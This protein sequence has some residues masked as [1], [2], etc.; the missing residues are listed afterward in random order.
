[1]EQIKNLPQQEVDI[2]MEPSTKE[3][4]KLNEMI[5][6]PD[7]M[8]GLHI[9]EAGIVLARYVYFNSELFTDKS[10]MELG[11]GVGVVGIALLKYCKPRSVE[12]SDYKEDILNN[13]V[14]NAKKNKVWTKIP[15]KGRL[16]DWVDY[17]K[18]KNKYDIIIGSDLIYAGAPV[19]ELSKL[20]NKMLNIGGK[21]Y[22]MIPKQRFYSVEFFKALD[23]LG[24]FEVEKIELNDEKYLTS[25]YWDEK[26]GYKHF[27]G[28]KELNF[29]V[30]ILTKVKEAN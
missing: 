13:A 3:H 10:I 24:N 4:L 9:W 14:N 23:E 7:R 12:I 5:I 26:A 29:F 21:V 15:T 20:M 18:E 8:D 2:L 11:T 1:M 27:A 17:E 19:V 28:L 22:I 25:P 16:L 30:Y 6:F